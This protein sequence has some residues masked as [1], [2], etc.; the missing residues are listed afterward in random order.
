MIVQQYLKGLYVLQD[1]LLGVIRECAVK[2]LQLEVFVS[3][4]RI[5]T[6]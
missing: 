6:K 1:Y 5:A 4:L 2:I 3:H